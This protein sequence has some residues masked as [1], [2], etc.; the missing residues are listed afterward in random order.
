MNTTQTARRSE[1]SDVTG[2][3]IRFWIFRDGKKP[4]QVDGKKSTKKCGARCTN[5]LGPSCSCECG[6]H[7]HGRSLWG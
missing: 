4:I 5:S 6:G 3:Q 1:F 2:D 7:N